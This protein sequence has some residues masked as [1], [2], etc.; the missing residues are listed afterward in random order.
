MEHPNRD[1]GTQTDLWNIAH[2]LHQVICGS[3]PPAKMWFYTGVDPIPQDLIRTTGWRL[4]E[5]DR[6][7]YSRKL[8]GLVLQSL[9]YDP[10]D[11]LPL[12]ELL[13]EV[14]HVLEHWNFGDETDLFVEGIQGGD[15][16]WQGDIYPEDFDSKEALDTWMRF[17][18]E[19]FQEI[20]VRPE[21]S[22]PRDWTPEEED[23]DFGGVRLLFPTR[24]DVRLGFREMP[25]ELGDAVRHPLFPDWKEYPVGPDGKRIREEKPEVRDPD[26][27]EDREK[28]QADEDEDNISTAKADFS[29][30]ERTGSLATS[31]KRKGISTKRMRSAAE[32]EEEEEEKSVRFSADTP[33]SQRMENQPTSRRTASAGESQRPSKRSRRQSSETEERSTPWSQRVEDFYDFE[34]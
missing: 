1:I 7:I 18:K 22:N 32:Q 28:E 12:H 19:Q 6:E 2:T 26:E 3:W 23:E 13:M 17:Q 8:R 4:L 30:A 16:G 10:A 9:A 29:D 15:V 14:Q 20:T 21:F 34:A 25:F 31:S 24:R 27:D 5:P 11:R 33:F